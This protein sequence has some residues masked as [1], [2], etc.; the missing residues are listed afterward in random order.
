MARRRGID[1]SFIYVSRADV[2]ARYAP[3]E[4]PVRARE[5]ANE[6]NLADPKDVLCPGTRCEVESEGRSL[7][8]DNNHL[9]RVGAMEI[10][11]SLETCL[12]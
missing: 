10:M 6:L 5:A 3:A 8:R 4:E 11:S 12:R 2:L 9:S 7:Y 1:P